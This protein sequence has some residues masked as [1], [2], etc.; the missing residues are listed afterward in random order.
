MS[1]T[2]SP[3][4][5]SMT[6]PK[7]AT[8]SV[9]GRIK[10]SYPRVQHLLVPLDFSGKSRQAL[11]YAVPLAQKFSAKIH[12]VHVLSV[13]RKT[14]KT[15]LPRL[16]QE[17]LKR[18]TQMAEQ[19]LPPKLHTDNLVLTGDPAQQILAA[20]NKFD[21]DMIVLTTKGS[22]GLKRILL[23]STAEH[24]M[25]HATCPVLSVRRH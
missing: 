12:L 7:A 8:D 11:R 9:L 19:L 18:L 16:K 24:I 21:I 1:T 20:A 3:F 2:I 25:R 13:D 17:A 23:G 5:K 10:A 15:T 4:P 14:D 6:S 22:S